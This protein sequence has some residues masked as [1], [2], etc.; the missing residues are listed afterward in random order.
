[1][2]GVLDLESK[3]GS[4]WHRWD[5]HLHTP[6]TA[7]NNQYRGASPWEDFLKAIETS[8]PPIR[9]LGITDYF[10]IE[11]YE[12]VLDQQLLGRLPD[13]G[14]IF[15][16]VELRLSIETAKASAINIHLLAGLRETSRSNLC[17][18]PVSNLRSGSTFGRNRRGHLPSD[19][20]RNEGFIKSMTFDDLSSCDCSMRS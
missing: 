9:A 13:V 16:N 6:G 10:G 4:L 18:R 2:G 7:L 11:R 5:P 19:R 15:P 3:Q 14:L 17:V 1:M 8:D 12:Q 20:T